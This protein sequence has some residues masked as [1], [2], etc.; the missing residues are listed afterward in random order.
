MINSD[1]NYGCRISDEWQLKGLKTVVME[2]E[3]LRITILADKG[4]DI[5]EFLYKPLDIDFMWRTPMGLRNPNNGRLT[6]ET[7]GGPFIDY[8]EGGWQEILPSGGAPSIYKGVEYGQ[9]GEISNLPWDCCVIKDHSEEVSCRFSVR[10]VR[11]PIYVEKILSI[12]HGEPILYIQEKL[13]NESPEQIDI[14][15]G[16]HLA[17][18]E[19]FLDEKCRIDSPAQK[20]FIHPESYSRNHRFPPGATFPWPDAETKQGQ[21][22]DFRT[23]PSRSQKSEDMTYLT[24]SERRVGFGLRWSGEIFK[25][26]WYWQVFGGG[27]GYP[28]YSRTYNI[29]LEPWTSYPTSGLEEAVKQGTHLTL[30]PNAEIQAELLAVVYSGLTQVTEITKQGK[31]S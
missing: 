21:A 14:M 4:S 7:A 10:A 24:H 26:L 20:I 22:V 9:H 12:K 27:E 30:E 13:I 6:K 16:H 11:T 8:Y 15:W 31:V 23:I 29:G 2:N 19:P 5:Y 28:W 3:Q 18:G 1:R 17:F 25:Y